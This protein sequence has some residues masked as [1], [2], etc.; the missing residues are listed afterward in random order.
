MGGISYYLENKIL[1]L[2]LCNTSFT[3]TGSELWLA[4]YST[5]PDRDNSGTELTSSGYARTKVPS[6]TISSYYT[7]TNACPVTFPTPTGTWG[8]VD[9][10][11]LLD[12]DTGGNLFFYGATNISGSIYVNDTVVVNPNAL[13]IIY[14]TYP[15]ASE[16]I[17]KHVFQNT[18]FT[19]PT[20]VYGALF[21][22]MPTIIP[23]GTN[24]GTDGIEIAGGSYSRQTTT[25]V[26][27]TNGSTSNSASIVFCSSASA[28]WGSSTVGM[29]L[30]DVA[31]GSADRFTNLL[32]R[33]DFTPSVSPLLTGESF[34]VRE[35]TANLTLYIDPAIT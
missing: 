7:A 22:L 27:P 6:F 11:G 8:K 29:C 3:A 9:Y 31:S 33:L 12:K 34:T 2:V 5:N 1:N 35:K 13:Q 4:L 19:P 14:Q 26:S 10:W 24:V 21:S 18:T 28:N 16:K 17:L 32:Y 23:D 25:W 30:L 15:Y 20:T